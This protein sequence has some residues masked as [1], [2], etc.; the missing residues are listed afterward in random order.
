MKRQYA[1]ALAAGMLALTACIPSVHPFYSDKDV[2]F[3]PRL[4]G[5]WLEKDKEEKPQSWHF[6]KAEDNAYR[7]SIT[8]SDGKC[9]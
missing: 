5:E 2:V 9:V 1:I 6:E 3:D 4:L 8:E 7:L